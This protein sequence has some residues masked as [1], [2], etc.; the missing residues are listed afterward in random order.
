MDNKNILLAGL[1][2]AG[3]ST[4]ITAL[5]AVEKD[6]KSGHLLIC[7][8]LPSE[9]SYIDGMRDNWMV[10]KEVR[11][12][13][14]AVPMQISLPMKSWRT[15]QKL[16]LSLPDF[17]GEI[18]Q[19]II[20]NMISED[21]KDWCKKSSGILFMLYLGNESPELLQEQVSESPEPKVELEKV[22]LNSNDI[23]LVIQNILLM[24]YL[25]EMMN[26]SPIAI[27]FSSWDKV[28]NPEGMS[29]EEWVKNNHPC[30]FNF[31]KEHFSNFCFYGVSAQGADYDDLNEENE[32][33]LAI[34]TTEKRRAYIFKENVS[35]DI[36]EPLDFLILE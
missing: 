11:R 7:D 16:T 19:R 29:V 3:K 18:Y 26:D 28:D 25:Y 32:D 9:S 4:Y 22:V 10:M 6:G 27:C 17:K 5:W 21:V 31:V 35:F 12:T 2:A 1:P 8:G 30:I 23:S 13:S 15:G 20:N 36:T 14:F 24:K 34:K 33:E